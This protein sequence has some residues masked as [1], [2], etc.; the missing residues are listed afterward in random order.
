MVLQLLVQQQHNVNNT[1]QANNTDETPISSND[2]VIDTSICSAE[3]EDEFGYDEVCGSGTTLKYLKPVQ[4]MMLKQLHLCCQL[5]KEADEV[6]GIK[7]DEILNKCTL[8]RTMIITSCM[9]S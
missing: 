6:K 5:A 7:A 3:S 9:L 1:V 8:H 4:F 2:T